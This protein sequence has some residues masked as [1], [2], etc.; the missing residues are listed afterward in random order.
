MATF[1][2]MVKGIDNGEYW[3]RPNWG[4][5]TIIRCGVLKPYEIHICDPWIEPCGFSNYNF[6]LLDFQAT[7][8]EKVNSHVVDAEAQIM[9]EERKKR[10]VR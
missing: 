9:R 6:N 3:R 1:D 5:Q 2:E 10:Y 8:W 4:S 7:D